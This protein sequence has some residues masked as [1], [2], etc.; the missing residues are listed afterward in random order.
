M[1]TLKRKEGWGWGGGGGNGSRSFVLAEGGG[2]G[3]EYR[4]LVY[5]L[6]QKSVQL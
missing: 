4:K 1:P 6:D 3:D 5:K 2:E